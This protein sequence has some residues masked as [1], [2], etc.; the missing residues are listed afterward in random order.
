MERINVISSTCCERWGRSSETSIP[1][2]PHFENLKGDGIIPPAWSMN[3]M[4]LANSRLGGCP[5]YFFNMGLGSNKSTWLGPPFINRWMTDFALGE[6]C[7][8]LARRS[9]IP[10]SD[11]A[12][13]TLLG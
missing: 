3:S 13:F 7:G 10:D 5:S 2:C 8:C 11:L 12:A 4:S 1:D 9:A 6:K